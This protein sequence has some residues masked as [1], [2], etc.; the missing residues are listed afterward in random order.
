MAK[1][2][3]VLIVI[4]DGIPVKQN[5]QD[6]ENNSL[7]DLLKEVL[8]NLSKLNWDDMT[9]IL[10]EKL[11]KQLDGSEWSYDNLNS[12]C[13]A[14]GSISGSA[15]DS[16]ERIFLIQVIKVLL[17]LTDHRKSKESKAVVASNLMHVV[18]QYPSFLKENW[19]FL[20]T[21]V[22][23]LFEFMAETFPGVMVSS[24]IIDPPLIEPPP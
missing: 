6:T 9:K 24:P 12:I 15:P 2:I 1:P 14:I 17:D 3:E 13:W 20:K 23:K 7:Y 18:S 19:S 11:N 22:K 5:L 10:L 4:E 16:E 8:T 21:V